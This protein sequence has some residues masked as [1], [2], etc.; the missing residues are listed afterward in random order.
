MSA[1]RPYRRSRASMPL[2]LLLVCTLGLVPETRA[3]ELQAWYQSTVFKRLNERWSV[4]NYLDLRATDGVG[5]LALG[6]VS[7]RVRYDF[8]PN[9]AGEVHATWLRAR[10]ASSS[11]KTSFERLELELNPRYGM[12]EGFT[13]SA[14]NRLELRWADSLPGTNERL[15][16]R[17]QLEWATPWAGPVAAVFANNEIFYDFDQGLVTENRLIPFGLAF[18]PAPSTDLRLYHLWRHTRAATRWYDFH[19]IGFAANFNF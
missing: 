18:R 2:A 16:I 4:G 7:P 8:S 6:M 11:T 3:D 9:W 17:P 15:R 19:A 10:S 1:C 13:F 14:R 5:P 12:G